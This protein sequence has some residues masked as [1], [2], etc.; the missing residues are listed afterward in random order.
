MYHRDVKML[1]QV[2]GSVH[3]RDVNVGGSGQ[4]YH[5]DVHAGDSGESVEVQ[6]TPK[7]CT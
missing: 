6:M 5:R 2:V 3:Y 1:L 4:A 7:G